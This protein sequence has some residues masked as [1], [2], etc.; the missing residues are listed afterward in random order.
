M[1]IALLLALLAQEPVKVAGDEVKPGLVAV[2]RSLVDP[3]AVVTRIDPKPALSVGDSS[4]HPAFRRGPS[5][6]SGPASS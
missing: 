3:D 1:G 2:Y 6:S 4:P 5:R